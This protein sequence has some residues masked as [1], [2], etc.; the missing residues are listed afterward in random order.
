[1]GRY[2]KFN[3]EGYIQAI[4]K[5]LNNAIGK[6]E[7]EVFTA[8]VNN[9]DSLVFRELDAKYISEMR[10]AI[11]YASTK[12]RQKIV[13]SIRAGYDSLPNQSF[14]LVY[15]EYGTG[16]KMKPPRD[17]SPNDD[18]TWNINRPRRIGEPVWT[19]PYGRW[20]DAGGNVHFS[21]YR[22]A[23][24]QLSS[25]SRRGQPIN[26]NYWFTRGFWEGSRNLNKYVLDAVKSVPIASYIN[27][28]NI[29][30]RM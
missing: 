27:I 30:K 10:R 23:P 5:S 24:R 9:F 4:E 19:R 6:V 8:I 15:Y 3:Q 11:R 12:T 18:P 21:N 17:Y 22:G 14:R 1:M 7:K 26:A 29:Y 20:E 2:V 16:I 25:L 28:A 13:S